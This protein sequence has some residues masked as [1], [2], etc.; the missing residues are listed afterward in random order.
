MFVAFLI[1][2]GLGWGT[3]RVIPVENRA[4]RLAVPVLWLIG[5]LAGAAFGGPEIA[6]IGLG[7][8]IGFTWSLARAA[9]TSSFEGKPRR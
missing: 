7:V 5:G 4:V 3:E 8:S 1:G 2:F 9:A 6:A